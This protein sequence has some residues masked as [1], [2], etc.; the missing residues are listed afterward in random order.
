MERYLSWWIFFYTFTLRGN[1]KLWSKE[2]DST[3][4]LWGHLNR[5][6]KVL[7]TWYIWTVVGS[8]LDSPGTDSVKAVCVLNVQIW[9]ANRLLPATGRK[10]KAK[11]E[12]KYALT[13]LWFMCVYG[14]LLH[15]LFFLHHG[16]ITLYRST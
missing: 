11:I 13:K 7:T 2:L 3:V 4:R 1:L 14:R 5:T 15:L 12:T 16:W 6:R 9:C 8:S 10:K